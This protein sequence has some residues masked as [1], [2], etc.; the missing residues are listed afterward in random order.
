[1]DSNGTVRYQETLIVEGNVLDITFSNDNKAMFYS[2][3]NVHQALTTDALLPR[4][5]RPF[6]G[7]FCL[8]Q[9]TSRWIKDVDHEGVAAINR[10]VATKEGLSISDSDSK[11][12]SSA[13]YG[14]EHLRKRAGTTDDFE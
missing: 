11:S 9:D 13:L 1:M 3:D 5:T 12:L 2:I 7:L 4:D 6:L 14:I 10:L 8:S